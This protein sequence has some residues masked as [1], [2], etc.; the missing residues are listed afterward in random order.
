M[1]ARRTTRFEMNL[2]GHFG[3]YWQK[4]AREEIAKMIQKYESG[5]LVIEADGAGRWKS[6]GHYIPDDCAVVAVYA[7]IPIDR[8][9]T[10]RARD[11]ENAEFFKSIKPRQPSAEE[12]A[13]M[14]NAFGAG[15]EVVN[16]LTGQRF[17]V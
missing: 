6:S 7:G 15:A 17:R 9:A 2:N 13:E 4:N 1:T 16:V 8:D 3:E 11:R 12:M 10:E 14:R 5:Q